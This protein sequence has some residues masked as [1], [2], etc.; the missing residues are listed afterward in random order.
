MYF[1]LKGWDWRLSLVF[2]VLKL[3]CPIPLSVQCIIFQFGV[4]M[5]PSRLS[6]RRS[7]FVGKTNVSQR[8]TIV[9]TLESKYDL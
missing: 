5:L 7:V 8:G 3:V 4:M 2:F 9:H 6:P 1:F